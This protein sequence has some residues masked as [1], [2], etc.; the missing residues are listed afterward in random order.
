MNEI[1][2]PSEIYDTTITSHSNSAHL[3]LATVKT[4]DRIVV[5]ETWRD[6]PSQDR[7]C[8]GYSLECWI[9]WDGSAALRFRGTTIIGRKL[10]PDG[11]VPQLAT[12][13]HTY[14]RTNGEDLFK[15]FYRFVKHC[16]VDENFSDIDVFPTYGECVK[17]SS[18]LVDLNMLASHAV[19]APTWWH[20]DPR[21]V[22]AHLASVHAHGSVRDVLNA[23]SRGIWNMTWQLD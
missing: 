7:N 17:H 10:T 14:F 13:K 15:S 19:D 23:I 12:M 9:N 2:N 22:I 21:V 20:E 1:N 6:A 8:S 11:W 4:N 3:C 16:V 5:Q 18:L